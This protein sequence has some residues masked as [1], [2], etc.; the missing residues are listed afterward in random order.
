MSGLPI[1]R[2]I[3]TDGAWRMTCSFCDTQFVRLRRDL[4]DIEAELHRAKCARTVRR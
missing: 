2:V 1:V 3:P 4:V